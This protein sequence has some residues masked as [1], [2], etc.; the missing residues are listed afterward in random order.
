[1][2]LLQDVRF[3]LRMM[4]KNPGFTA[5]AVLALA[6]G[7]GADTTVFTIVN[8]ILL[9]NLPFKDGQE[10]VHLGSV[11]LTGNS[12]TTAVSYPDF[13]DWRTQTRSLQ[14]VAAFTI[15]TMNV[16]DNGGVPERLS[17]AWLTTNAFRIIGLTPIVGRDFMSA[18]GRRGSQPVVILG[19][20][21]WQSRYGGSREILGK[22]I[23]I[24]AVP[25]V[26]IGVMPQGMKF[27]F[28]AELW[29]PLIQTQERE[30]RDFRDLIVFG[31]LG[32]GLSARQAHVELNA[33]AARLAEA[34]PKTNAGVA[35]QVM[36]F[37]DRYN[38]GR[39]ATVL[40]IMMGAVGFVLMIA[41][42]NVAN[43]LLSRSVCR[44]REISIRAAVGA[45]R[46]RIIRQLLI[47]SLLLA[48]AGGALG[49][50]L[51]VAGVRWFE[52]SL[53]R[54]SIEGIPYWL[55]FSMDWKVF[56]Y[57]CAVCFLTSMAF[58]L[59]PAL[60]VTKVNLIEALKEGGHG[61][62]AGSKS[63]RWTSGLVVTQLT[64]T[65]VLLS[66]AGMMMQDFLRSQDTNV[67]SDPDNVLT[68]RLGLPELKYGTPDARIAF[69]EKLFQRLRATP[70][71]TALAM[72][73]HL[74]VDGSISGT[75]QMEGQSVDD[76]EKLPRVPTIAVSPEYF[77]TLGINLARGRAFD[78]QDGAPG[79]EVVIVNERF[80]AA[81][82]PGQDPLGKRIRLNPQSN[83]PWLR[84]VGVV[85]Q[86]NQE[87]EKEA[88][89]ESIVYVPYR[90]L[91]A[92][93]V[94]LA[95]RT[96]VP[97]ASLVQTVRRQVESED[98]DLPLYRI[99]TLGKHLSLQLWPY[100]VFGALF[101]A[102][103][104]IALVLSAIGIYGVTAFWVNQRTREIGLR[105]ALGADGKDVRWLVL[106]QGI[107]HLLVGLTLGLV[108]ALAL[109]R[110]LEGLLVATSATDP[111]ANLTG[112]LAV[113][114]ITLLS[115]MIPAWRASRLDPL[116]ALRTG[117]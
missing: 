74:P 3:A 38:A 50:L 14:D 64:L 27:P 32:K 72:T 43:L 17:G 25:A 49:L 23:R 99:R 68:M 90:Q 51:A 20:G 82:W 93:F 117:T 40:W 12:K 4:R 65:L 22:V 111:A 102:F 36:S 18:E 112:L 9:K 88:D 45:G 16:S 107:R 11:R 113:V 63:G 13:N 1:M 29:M 60:K 53:S 75:L 41:C 87:I 58:G 6:L 54:A 92:R 116:Y 33:I 46:G 104:V 100:R 19:N 89:F 34:Y 86:L 28:D 57:L 39:M 66:S 15:G 91:P 8:T 35:A 26:V 94:S 37:N 106:R 101:A 95:M 21:I 103:A 30:A 81:H 52:T 71:I 78:A 108:G 84:V 2:S 70:G 59:A 76:I 77:S 55:D 97:P 7:V 31:R 5:V 83:A 80:V 47:E 98:P 24:N 85:P 42:V 10:I 69:H 105:M 114:L 62:D 67:G 48:F 61:G 56:G 109:G 44:S 96:R 73:S 79:D 110:F 115:C